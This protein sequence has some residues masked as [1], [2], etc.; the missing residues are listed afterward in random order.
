MSDG[1]NALG[2]L[3]QQLE[4]L[5]SDPDAQKEWAKDYGL[6]EL[7]L[8]LTDE[9]SWLFDLYREE[10]LMDKLDETSILNLEEHLSLG[11]KNKAIRT[12]TALL[13]TDPFWVRTRELAELV[14]AS[15]SRH[16]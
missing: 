1:T 4:I 16:G 14:L 9:G 7:Y 11:M 3:V 13:Y 10:E 5:A 8:G 6:Q 12:Q 15:L 2:L